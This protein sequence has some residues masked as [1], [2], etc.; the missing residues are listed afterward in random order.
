MKH[1]EL[2]LLEPTFKNTDVLEEY[3]NDQQDVAVFDVHE[4]IGGPLKAECNQGSGKW[5]FENLEQ[6]YNFFQKFKDLDC[7]KFG[8]MNFC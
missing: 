7:K 6:V 5:K 3:G 1:V 4:I 8:I 2:D